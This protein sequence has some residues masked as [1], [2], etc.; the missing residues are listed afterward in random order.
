MCVS[1]WVGGSSLISLS[2]F[3]DVTLS[4]CS[5]ARQPVGV[6]EYAARGST[7]SKHT[8]AFAQPEI[9]ANG[10]RK[11]TQ[12]WMHTCLHIENSAAATRRSNVLNTVQLFDYCSVFISDTRE[13]CM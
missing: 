11:R 5:S 9:D 12:V 4:V 2:L 10:D 13:L 7:Q 3:I 8:H 6:C 1:V